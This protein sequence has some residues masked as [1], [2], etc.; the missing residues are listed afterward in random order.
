MYIVAKLAMSKT[1]TV[2]NGIIIRKYGLLVE[3][4]SGG[5]EGSFEV[6]RLC[7]WPLLLKLHPRI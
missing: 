6:S 5:S 2:I 4:L 7:A 3:F 1:D